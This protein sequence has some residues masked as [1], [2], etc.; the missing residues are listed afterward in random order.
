MRLR[1]KKAEPP[2]PDLTAKESILCDAFA[3]AARGDGWIPYPEVGTWDLVLVHE[4]EAIQIGV[5]AKLRANV[6]VL[7]QALRGR[8][9]RQGPRFRAVLVPK[10]SEAFRYVAALLGVGVYTERHIRDIPRRSHGDYTGRRY[11]IE[12]LS[13][14]WEHR[15]PL[16]LP[17]VVPDMSGGVPAPSGLTRWRVQAIRL[18]LRLEARGYVTSKDFN[19]LGISAATWRDRWIVSTG[20]RDGRR[21][22]YRAKPGAELPIEGWREQAAEIGAGDPKLETIRHAARYAA[23]LEGPGS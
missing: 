11:R 17:P 1:R 14:P 5:Q 12:A 19:E 2:R 7:R 4:E 13:R 6:E 3:E 10:C 21:F 18:C 20:E 8:Q 15:D 22:L 9:W 23:E 16:W